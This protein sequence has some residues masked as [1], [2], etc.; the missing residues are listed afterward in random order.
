[1]NR[2][3]QP[4][5]LARPD[6]RPNAGYT[7]L[8]VMIVLVVSAALFIGV[9]GLFSN[10]QKEVEFTQAVRG[11]EAKVQNMLSEVANG[12]YPNGYHCSPGASD[13][14]LV[15]GAREDPGSQEDCIFIGKV[16][17]SGTT[18]SQ[19]MTVL[20]TRLDAS[21]NEIE[22]L[23]LSRIRQVNRDDTVDTFKNNYGLRITKVVNLADTTMSVANFG[24]FA[25]PSGGIAADSSAS[26]KSVYL[27]AIPFSAI[28]PSANFNDNGELTG[29]NDL[30]VLI[31]LNS[32][33]LMCLQHGTDGRRAEVR[34]GENGTQTSITS[35]LNVTT[36][37]CTT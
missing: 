37:E 3:L 15:T 25:K 24:F 5:R 33:L 7:V 27:Y 13:K 31:Q 22:N 10:R 19:I 23:D 16:W 20:S 29:D 26:G 18:N 9:A 12:Y 30:N 2:W 35:V 36:G 6:V 4:R 1:M 17:I 32:G 28:N 14:P 11:F 8:E 34:I 21:G